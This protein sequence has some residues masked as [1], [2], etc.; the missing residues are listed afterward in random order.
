MR[1]REI[2]GKQRR[3]DRERLEVSMCDKMFQKRARAGV[4]Q[5]R[6]DNPRE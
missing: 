3:G 2:G 1:E 6:Q 5:P 4:G